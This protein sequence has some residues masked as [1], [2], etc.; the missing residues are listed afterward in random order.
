MPPSQPQCSTFNPVVEATNEDTELGGA[1]E[2]SSLPVNEVVIQDSEP[3]AK[4][5]DDDMRLKF[6]ANNFITPR[7]VFDQANSTGH[8]QPGS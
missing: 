2:E 4:R 1:D 8:K 7:N 5:S 3:S 6:S